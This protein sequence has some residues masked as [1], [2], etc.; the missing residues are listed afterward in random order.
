ML[1]PT[2]RIAVL[3]LAL[4]AGLGARAALRIDLE[5]P[6][7]GEFVVDKANL[8]TLED[9]NDIN[10]IAAATL[11]DKAIPIITVTIDRMADYGGAGMRIETFATLLYNE[12]EVGHKELGGE[13]WNK[14]ILLLVSKDD[15]YARIELGDGWDRAASDTARRVMDEQIIPLFKRGEYSRGILRGVTALND[16]ARG[17]SLPRRPVNWWAI[18]GLAAMSGLIV[19]TIVSFIRQ[20]TG[21]WA[22]LFWGALFS[23]L[24]F[25]LYS[26]MR[27]SG[28]VGSG[29]GFSG[30]SFG[31]GFSSGGGATGSW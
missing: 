23:V 11:K 25:V 3:T 28:G 6:P 16:M 12:W 7:E 13:Y 27:G 1:H 17:E 18:L 15:R 26:A 31:G 8:I 5:P 20:G 22:W 19:F 2:R 24:G 29:G 21:G 9:Q 4:L 10:K 14:G 30:G